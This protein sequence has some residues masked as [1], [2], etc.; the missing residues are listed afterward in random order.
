MP[1]N[2]QNNCLSYK[3][4]IHTAM[5]KLNS[6]IYGILFIIDEREQVIGICTDG[7]IRRALLQ[8]AS[9]E[10]N[11][12]PYI[13]RNFE[14]ATPNETHEAVIAK[15]SD[16]IKHIPILDEQKKLLEFFSWNE[17]IHYP[18]M[19]PVLGGNELKYVTDCITSGWISSQGSYV[20]SFEAHFSEHLG[21]D[22]T[23]AT[24]SGTSAL[25]LALKALDIKEG[26]EVLVPNLTFAATANVVLHCG[27]KPILVDVDQ[28]TWNFDADKA[29]S[30]CSSATKA[31]IPVHL[32]GYPCDMDS[33]IKLAREN[34]L[35]VIED[36]AEAHGAKYKGK[37]VGTFGDIACFSFFSNKVMT[38]GEGGMLV[39]RDPEIF[40]QAKIL[41]D[42]GMSPEKRYWHEYAGFNFRMTNMQAAIGVAQLEKIDWFIER[43]K[44]I[45]RH[46]LQHLIDCPNLQMPPNEEE[47]ESI[48]WIFT[49]LLS[50][51]CKISRDDLI[52]RL[53]KYNIDTRPMFYPLNEQPP[54]LCK[55]DFPVSSSI[56]Y[57]GISLPSSYELTKAEIRHICKVLIDCVKG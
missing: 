18:L 8:D 54:Y 15:L 7:D 51:D 35:K 43:R 50:E 16:K 45:G 14:Y 20:K 3:E 26:D 39:S 53:K 9:L 24:S 19:S 57:R 56:A 36:C 11:I 37:P 33:I 32:Y 17:M 6:G 1:K 30:L 44:E 47:T 48:Y 40:E 27:A 2:L 38:T 34:N 22:Y 13:N 21:I 4:T 29:K 25:H 41:R 28:N 10:D 42:H 12:E 5:E 55:K 52:K 31:I 49:L 46:Y 23:L